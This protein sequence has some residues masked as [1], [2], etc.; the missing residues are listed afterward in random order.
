MYLKKIVAIATFFLITLVIICVQPINA[1]NQD[2]ITTASAIENS[3][4]EKAPMPNSAGYVSAVVDEKIY[5]VGSGVTQIYDPK[6]DT[7]SLGAPP[8][9]NITLGGN[10]QSAY[11]AATTGLLAPKRI[12]VYDGAYLQ[13]YNPDNKSWIFGANPPINRQY[14]SIAVLNDKLYFIGGFTDHANNI[15]GYFQDYSTN[16]QYTPFGYGTVK[17]QTF[18]TATVATILIVTA[19]VIGVGLI[20]YFKKRHQ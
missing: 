10:G 20:V 11:A 19:V 12:Y 16:E 1:Q 4:V 9:E 8:L 15:P 5:V 6:T 18:P 3:W 14:L 7:W 13:V 2:D 17:Q